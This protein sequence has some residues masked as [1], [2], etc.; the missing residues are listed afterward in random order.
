MDRSWAK[1][2]ITAML[3]GGALAGCAGP[4]RVRWPE[5]PGPVTR[6][7]SGQFDGT[8]RAAGH[9]G[10]EIDERPAQGAA[11]INTDPASERAPEQA[12]GTLSIDA[13]IRQALAANA[14]VRAA[15]FNVEAL[16]QRLP[17][18]TALD[19]PILSNT[20]FPIPSVAPQYS[21]M[22]YMP[23]GALLA[24]QFPWCGTLR[25]RGQ[26]AEQDVRIALYELAATELDTVAGVKRAYHDLHFAEQTETL[27]RQNR[28]LALE[29][30][31]I[32]RVRYP[33]TTATQ[34]D[35]LRAEVAVSDIDRE[36]ENNTAAISEARAE[37]A[38]LLHLDPD[39]DHEIRTVPSL[40]VD[41]VPAQLDGLHQLALASRPD[42]QGR[43]AAIDRDQAA[44]EL[45][46][47]RYYPNLTL[48]VVYQDM[49]KTNALTPRT[50]GGMP[51]VGLFVG[52]N[53]PV[54]QK[55]LAAGVCEAQA[56]AAAD[57]ALYEAE[58]DQS[59]RDVKSLFVQARV[60]QNVINLLRK[61]N[62]PSA[63]RVLRLTSSEYRA[64]V[65][66]VDLLTLISAWRDLLQVELQ[67]AQVE[68]ELGK[69]LASLERAVGTQLNE[70]P[71]E[72]NESQRSAGT[73]RAPAERPTAAPSLA[74]PP[75]S[76]SPF[77]SEARP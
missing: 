43:L 18:V 24:Q 72:P 61:S 5:P 57:R 46:R 49:E 36:I 19:D 7:E 20:I 32:A 47:K 3:L 44:I 71:L 66:G 63:Q 59:H 39:H 48:G 74:S 15:R 16:R 23:Y 25:L 21:L 73:A 2:T 65:A 35:V 11:T 75:A 50:A 6:A 8:V 69:T 40:P 37:L 53:L 14:S 45:A 12:S 17:Q 31:E 34:P 10:A 67:I 9:R 22:G 70:H 56:R 76:R 77:R 4:N 62:L 55:K 41:S 60:Q 68:A 42:L 27:L 54:Y 26:A 33:T 13:C 30:L 52:M 29:F 51:N 28:R 1:S 64:N 58:R 38:R